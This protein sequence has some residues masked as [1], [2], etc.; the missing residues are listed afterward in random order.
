M[1]GGTELTMTAKVV[2]WNVAKRHEPWRRLVEM[3]ADVALLQEAGDPPTDVA[4]RVDTGPREH[5]DSHV[6]NSEWHKGRYP[7]LYDRWA[8][9]VRLSDRVEVEWFKQVSPISVPAA[10]EIAVSGIGTVAAARVARR[11]LPCDGAGRRRCS[12]RLR[13]ESARAGGGVVVGGAAA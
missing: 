5:W 2:C 11:A 10:H 12:R 3:G 4:G 1:V 6:W 7:R 8:K 13:W 9:V